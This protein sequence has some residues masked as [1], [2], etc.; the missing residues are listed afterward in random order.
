MDRKSLI[1]AIREKKSYLCVGLDTDLNKIPGSFLQTDDPVF[2]FNK[3]VIDATKD[4]CVAYKLNLAFYESSGLK[5]WQSLIKTVSYIPDNIFKIADAK[6][7]DIGNTSSQ[8]AKAFF[9]EMPFDAITVSPYMGSDSVTPFYNYPG[10]WVIILALTS[11]KGSADFQMLKTDEEY[12]FER[13]LKTASTW[14]SAENTMFV[15]GATHPGA[16]ESIRKIVPDHFLLIPGVGAQ[17]GTVQDVS[18]YALNKDFGIIIN[19]SRGILFPENDLPF[20]DN[21]SKA[22]FE[23]QQQMKEF[24]G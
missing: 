22:A 7:G 16:F 11:N 20:P 18:K 19:V 15:V 1:A 21:I 14:G 17:G 23:Y 3:A 8:Y 6:R 13:V 9:S 10:K 4:C 12:L 2:E 24:I 5:G